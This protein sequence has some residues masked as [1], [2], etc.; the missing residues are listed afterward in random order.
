MGGGTSL[1]GRWAM[2]PWMRRRE[3]A[4]GFVRFCPASLCTTCDPMVPVL[5]V[6]GM[7]IVQLHVA[8]PRRWWMMWGA[9]AVW[10][11]W[12]ATERPIYATP[13]DLNAPCRGT[14]LEFPQG[15]SLQVTGATVTGFPC[16]AKPQDLE[17]R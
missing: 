14:G 12:T 17:L 3:R 8:N 16:V 6:T 9:G 4:G 10:K 13:M 2:E 1:S 11:R 7:V 5:P 15:Q